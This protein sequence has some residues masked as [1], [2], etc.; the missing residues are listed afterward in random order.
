M[1]RSTSRFELPGGR[2]RAAT[3]LCALFAVT[4]ALALPIAASG[5]PPIGPIP[6]TA[7][8]PGPAVKGQIE[9]VHPNNMVVGAIHTVLAHPT[10]PKILYIGAVNGGIWKTT[11]AQ[12]NN[13]NW[14]PL[15][16]TQATSAIGAMAFDTTDAT[17]NTIWAGVGKYSSFG[18]LG[19]NR[20][21]LYK[22]TNGGSS[23]T[24]VTG[25]G[26]LLGKNIS[27]VVA[28]GNT[29]V[30]SVNEADVNSLGNIGI[31]RSTNG[32]ATFAQISGAAGT[33]LPFG[34]THDLVVD[35][36]NPAR[37]FTS[38][39]FATLVPG[40]INGVY[41]SL[42]TGATWA[43]VSN[44]AMDAV[45]TNSASNTEFAVGLSNNVYC[46]IVNPG[47]LAGLFRS[48]DGGTTWTEMDRPRTGPNNVGIHPGAQ[49][50]IHLSILADRT[51]HSLVYI[52][53][54]RQPFRLEEGLSFPPQFPNSIGA[55]N[56]SG[57]LF[58]C[59]ASLAPGSQCTPLTNVGTASNSS[60]HAD[61][62]EMTFDAS[63]NIVETDDGGVYRRTSPTTAAGNWFSVNG[64]LQVT[65]EHDLSYDTLA[66]VAFTGTQDNDDPHQN[67][68][69]DTEWFVLLSGD[70]GDTAVDNQTLG[71][72]QSTRF[73]SAQ[74]LQAFVRTFWDAT[75]D[76]LGFV[77]PAL[78]PLD[79]APRCS[80]QFTTPVEINAIT[81]T[82]LIFGCAN[83]TYETFDQGDTI[84]RISTVVINGS[85]IE[86]VSY[87]GVGNPDLLV[88]GSGDRVFIRTAAHPAPL[89]QNA[90]YPG[91][92]TGRTVRDTVIDPANAG[93]IY[94]TNLTQVFQTLD[95][96]ATWTD[97]SGN[98]QS[99]API[100][101]RAIEYIPRG[102]N[103]AL[104]VSTF[105]GIYVSYEADGFDVWSPLGT[106]F[107]NVPILDLQYD[108][109]NNVLV[110]GTLGR[111]TWKLN[112]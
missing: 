111:G 64:D 78:T 75:N 12:S 44:A 56:F 3:G 51:N 87:G 17:S 8:G 28:Q 31:W 43:K 79:G 112:L 45:L 91:T 65:E 39:T 27:G 20:V 26:V 24:N 14:L 72:G 22:T 18:R 7:Q 4:V 10:D 6:W 108:A 94:L 9:N 21:G 47:R 110:A 86:P 93:A 57:R 99:F 84:R 69:N 36:T 60:P 32:G 105:N 68:L 50:S 80:G 98:I 40:G 70:G 37:L 48:G 100:A 74:G 2:L 104:V 52:G 42:D 53:G 85:G 1:L 89:T 82:R 54:D 25:G 46:A 19:G 63:G 66:D 83:G 59:D 107:P 96:G 61:S 92:G 33:G 71:P 106:G 41:R 15:T 102:A 62:R 38:V 81:K 13:P 34:V 95:G 103:D 73:D 23:W 30:I 49:G 11:N 35:S 29:I 5:Q 90:T 101:L 55:N 88:V 97:V 67:A 109:E 58:R 77:F 76:L 16:D